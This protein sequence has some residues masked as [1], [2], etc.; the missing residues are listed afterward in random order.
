MRASPNRGLTDTKFMMPKCRIK[1]QVPATIAAHEFERTE[2]PRPLRQGPG[3]ALPTVAKRRLV[4]QV[5]QPD[6][7]PATTGPGRKPAG[8]H[9]SPGRWG[10]GTYNFP[11][12]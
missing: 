5:M 3:P 6:S 9:K 4:P 2:K 1:R 8:E 11:F 7:V 10:R 12:G